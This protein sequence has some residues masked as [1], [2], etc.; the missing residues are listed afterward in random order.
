MPLVEEYQLTSQ[1]DDF[2]SNFNESIE[3]FCNCMK[4]EHT[5][6]QRFAKD[7]EQHLLTS[8]KITFV[9]DWEGDE[10][11]LSDLKGLFKKVFKKYSSR[12]T[13][14]VTREGNSIVVECYIPSYLQGV[15]TR[16]VE[17]AEQ[18]LDEEKVKS[19]NIGGFVVFKRITGV[20]HPC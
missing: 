7:F 15:F 6:G 11:F 20:W 12:L 13:I 18:I 5:Y 9:L 17:D 19:V 8:E 2:I 1:D 14:L 10:M 4:I 3:E 16:L